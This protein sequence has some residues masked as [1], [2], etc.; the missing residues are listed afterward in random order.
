MSVLRSVGELLRGALFP[1]PPRQ[2]RTLR[3]GA[4]PRL[5]RGVAAS[6][7]V[8]GHGQAPW[9]LPIPTFYLQNSIFFSGAEGIRTPDLRRAKALRA[10][11]MR[12]GASACVA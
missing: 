6:L 12:P 2:E 3:D 9:T 4:E 10:F 1:A 5:G 8:R 11:R 7:A